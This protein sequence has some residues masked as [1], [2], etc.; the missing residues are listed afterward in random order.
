MLNADLTAYAGLFILGIIVVC[1]VLYYLNYKI[2]GSN[3]VGVVVLLSFWGLFLSL[4]IVHIADFPD[5]TPATV[6]T[7]SICT[8]IF[9]LIYSISKLRGWVTQQKEE[10]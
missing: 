1:T 6:L 5:A 7:I 9:P 8:I 3:S 4:G 2:D 10:G